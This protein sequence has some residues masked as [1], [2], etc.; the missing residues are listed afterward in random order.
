MDRQ[1]QDFRSLTLRQMAYA[2]AAGDAGNVTAA[3]RE[4]SVSQPSISAAIAG[5][6]AHY[7]LP[8]FVRLP[9]QGVEPTSFGYDVLR[10]MREILER[11]D[12]AAALARPSKG[13]RGVVTL[14]CYDALAPYLLPK[15]LRRVADSLPGLT[16]RFIEGSLDS[17]ADM[18]TRETAEL[19]VTYDLGANAE[20]AAKTIY[21]LQPRILCA[22]DHPFA[23]RSSVS[24]SELSGEDLILL[25]QPMS[26]QYVL[27]LLRAAGATP[28]VSARVKG[29]ELQRAF[30]ANGLGIAVTHTQPAAEMSYDGRPLK[31]VRV[32]D[33]L[34]PQK[35]LLIRRQRKSLRPIVAR[36]EEVIL[37]A[38]RED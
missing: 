4:L 31:A 2:L 16:I 8:L 20:I 13:E 35:V 6:E 25:D 30:V 1:N 26:A 32:A 36:A 5:L 3:A 37:A 18:V 17:V 15:M 33:D 23:M 14:A 7:G 11:V 24:L 38:L 22:A 34:P 10:E 9:G 29:F 28:K 27:G 12:V 21:K 19:G